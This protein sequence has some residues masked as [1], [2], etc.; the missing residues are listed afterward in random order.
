MKRVSPS[1][2]TAVASVAAIYFAYRK[3][4]VFVFAALIV[5][6]QCVVGPVFR[7]LKKQSARVD[8]VRSCVA[9]IALGWVSFVNTEWM[10]WRERIKFCLFGDIPAHITEFEG[11]EDIWTDYVIAMKFKADPESI[12]AILEN[13]KFRIPDFMSSGVDGERVYLPV[14]PDEKVMHRVTT[15]ASFSFMSIE[16]GVD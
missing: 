14:N 3:I 6:L 5:T 16:Y 4:N 9:V 13:G 12:R 1:L 11:Y 10:V 7:K 2:I 8:W 15:D